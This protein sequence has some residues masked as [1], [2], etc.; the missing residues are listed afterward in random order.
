MVPVAGENA[1]LN[2]APVERKAHVRAAIIK[3][4]HVVAIGDD[5]DRA[6]WRADYHAAAVA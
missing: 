6:A 4:D 1:V 5:K 3:R 2:A